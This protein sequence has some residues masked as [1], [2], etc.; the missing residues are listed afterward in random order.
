M[1]WEYTW[2]MPRV[3]EAVSFEVFDEGDYEE[4]TILRPAASVSNF[5]NHRF[6]WRILESKPLESCPHP[7][8]LG[9]WL[10]I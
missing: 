2:P 4:F 6:D 1:V 5:L 7:V 3:I 9:V 8:A 10:M